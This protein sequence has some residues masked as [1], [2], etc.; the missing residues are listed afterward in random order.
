MSELELLSGNRAWGG[1]VR[2][3]RHAAQTTGCAMEFSVFLPPHALQ[4]NEGSGE[5]GERFPLFT[6]LSGLTCTAENFTTKAGAQRLAAERGWMLL[7][8]DTSPRGDRVPDAPERW[9]L[10]QGAGFYVDATT[11]GWRDNYRMYSYVTDELP[12]LVHSHLPSDPARQMISGHSMGGHG[13]LICA[14]RNPGR[15]RSVSAF[16]P[17]VTPSRVPWGRDAF[18]TYLGTDEQAW[19]AWDASELVAAI[20]A[21]EPR[22]TLLI[23]QGDAD[24]FLGEQ[25]EPEAFA[26]RC[27]ELGHP[28]ELRLRPGYDHSYWYVQTFLPEH[29]AWHAEA[30]RDNP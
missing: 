21:G 14:L 7:A 18:T 30:L 29:F 3:Y 17:I 5:A 4:A 9:D 2:T 27:E 25:L 22:Q 24:P 20:G 28:C 12:E 13:A 26:E 15:Y 16:A 1:E 6:W 19:K 8:P 11:E 10:G 23:D